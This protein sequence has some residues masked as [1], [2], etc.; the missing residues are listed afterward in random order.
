VLDHVGAD[1]GL[2][3]GVGG[4][5]GVEAESFR[6]AAVI[7]R[8][9]QDQVIKGHFLIGDRI[10]D[11]LSWLLPEM[12]AVLFDEGLDSHRSLSDH[13]LNDAVLAQLNLYVRLS[14]SQ[15]LHPK[16]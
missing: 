8:S 11:S 1:A 7:H 13:P 3:S 9:G 14:N 6:G 10:G 12:G 5:I 2:G 15:L 4:S 16:Q